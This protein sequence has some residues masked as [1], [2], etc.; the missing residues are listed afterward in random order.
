MST[1]AANTDQRQFTRIAFD[2][3]VSLHNDAG[4]WESTLM[5]I[6]LKGVL[7]HR[8]DNWNDNDDNEFNIA[9]QLE[10]HDSGIN[11]NVKL[12]HAVNDQLGF[13]CINIDLDSVT[14]L[15]RLVELNLGNEQLL[16]RDIS[17]MLS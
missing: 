16:E 8:P 6:S 15:R 9:V 7:I 5:D 11:M 4:R 2:A 1:E 14:I 3:P 12:V 13:Q 10:G 17:N